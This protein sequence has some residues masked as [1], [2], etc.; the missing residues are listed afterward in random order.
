MSVHANTQVYTHAR[1][2]A[3]AHTY[4]GKCGLGQMQRAERT[5][6]EAVEGPL[7]AACE[8]GEGLR[9]TLITLPKARAHSLTF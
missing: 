4:K 7:E 8:E 3:R 9:Q 5:S 2:H 1:G 6:A